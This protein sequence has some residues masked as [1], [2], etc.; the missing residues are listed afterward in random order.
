MAELVSKCPDRFIAAVAC[1]PMNDI[2]A[3]L[4]EAER[5][6]KELNFKGV[7]IYSSINEAV[8]ACV[9]DCMVEPDFIEKH[10]NYLGASPVDF[11][12]NFIETY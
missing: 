1:L 5:A 4:A 10:E 2:D 8:D 12:N 3:A 7:Q 6:V 11:D 9:F